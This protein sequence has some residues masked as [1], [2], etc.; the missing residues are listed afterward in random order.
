MSVACSRLAAHRCLQVLAR[1]CRRLRTCAAC[2]WW[3]PFA[4]SRARRVADRNRRSQLRAPFQ[5]VAV[6]CRPR[7]RLGVGCRTSASA[8]PV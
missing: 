3:F 2:S 5:P 1:A 4:C 8:T 7:P 6:T